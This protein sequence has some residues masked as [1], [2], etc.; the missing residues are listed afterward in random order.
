MLSPDRTR[1]TRRANKISASNQDPTPVA[2]L[3]F[4]FLAFAFGISWL[5]WITPHRLGARPGVGEDILA[6]GSAGPA[7]AAIVLSRNG[8]KEPDAGHAAR[9][10]WFALLW[11]LCWGLYVANDK[12]RLATSSLSL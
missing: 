9:A 2:K 12:M 3:Y 6:F 5:V 10:I 4:A 11:V 8:R 7:I 1:P